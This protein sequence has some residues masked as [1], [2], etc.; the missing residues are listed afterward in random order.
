MVKNN[1]VKKIL[2]KSGKKRKYIL[3]LDDGVIDNV[4]F[5][6]PMEVIELARKLKELGF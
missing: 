3:G 5:L 2:N 6:S 1:R 4:V